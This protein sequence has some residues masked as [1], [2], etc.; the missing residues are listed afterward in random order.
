MDK[1]SLL[2]YYLGWGTDQE[3]SIWP[4]LPEYASTKVLE[5]NIGYKSLPR[6]M[7]IH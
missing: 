2:S 7:G 3:A 5:T 4:F 6:V 1:V